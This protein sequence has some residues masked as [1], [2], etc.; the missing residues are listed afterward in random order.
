MM[1][2]LVEEDAQMK[3]IFEEC[4]AGKRTC[5]ACK[6]EV[7]ELMYSFIKKHQEDRARAKEVLKE[8]EVYKHWLQV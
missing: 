4:K 6:L 1:F 5:K 2:H 7:A 8:H 3:E